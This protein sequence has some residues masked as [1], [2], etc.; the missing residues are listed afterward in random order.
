MPRMQHEIE[1]A[2]APEAVFDYVSTPGR[3]P[4]WHPS[5]L[6]LE[7]GAERPLAAGARFEED[8][9]AGGRK[10]HLSW[11]VRES[12]RPS[13]WTA[14]AVGDNGVTLR[15]EYRLEVRADGGTRFMRTLDYSLL[16][17]LLRTY[18]ALLGQR[19]IARESEESLRRLRDVMAAG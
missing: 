17:L 9:H 16:N 10:A 6:R 19:R 14:E 13:L 8:I 5:S 1:I 11:I 15:L 2:A 3:W 12:Q 7:S 18:N 4:E